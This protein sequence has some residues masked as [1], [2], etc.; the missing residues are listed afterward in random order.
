MN[1]LKERKLFKI[2]MLKQLKGNYSLI[3][4]VVLAPF[5]LSMAAFSLLRTSVKCPDVIIN[6]T[7]NPKPWEKMK[8]DQPYRMIQ[9]M[10]PNYDDCFID[11]DKPKL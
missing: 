10:K 3:P 6:R 7:S 5:A 2:E 4:I 9:F 1:S 11:P 8:H